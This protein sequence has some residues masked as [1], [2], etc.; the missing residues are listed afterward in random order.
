M[1][2]LRQLA[3]VTGAAQWY[4]QSDPRCGSPR[5][6]AVLI[7]DISE[8]AASPP[9]TSC[10]TRARRPIPPARRHQRSD[11][12]SACAK[13][14]DEF[15]G[16]DI[17]VNNAG[18]GTCSRSRTPRWP[19]A[20]DDRHRP[21]RGLPRMRTA[22]PYLKASEHASVSN[23]SFHLRLGGGFGTPRLPRRQG[24]RST[25][26]KNVACTGRRPSYG[27]TPSTPVSQ[28]PILRQAKETEFWQTMTD[29]TP[30]P[31]R[32]TGGIAAGVA[33]LASDDATFITGSSCISTV[34][35]GR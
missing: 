6:A 11:W 14:V 25:L 9:P 27:S 29:L 12:D 24:R 3:L 5:R 19:I 22:A 8:D 23:I 1:R 16:L 26:T 20:A 4:R 17:L 7:T 33:Y 18:M 31:S 35:I 13:A 28:T 34:A 30:R 21:D 32:P 10:A 15:G 2:C